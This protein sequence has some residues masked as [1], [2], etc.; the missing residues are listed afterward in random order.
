VDQA[1][2]R[3]RQKELEQ[4]LLAAPASTWQEAAVKTR[5]L[6]TLFAE[7]STAQD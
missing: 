1:A 6:I 5:Y 2:L 4:Y 3:H 7:T